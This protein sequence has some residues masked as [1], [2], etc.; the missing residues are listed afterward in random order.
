MFVAAVSWQ[1]AGAAAENPLF[2]SDI[3]PILEKN[4]WICHRG[5]SA[6]AGLDMETYASLLKGGKSGPPIHQGSAGRSLLVEKISSGAMPPGKD[7]LAPEQIALI[8]LWIDHG[9]SEAGSPSGVKPAP[10]LVT[11]DDVLPIFQMRC[12]VCHGKR[13]QEG[14]L[15]LRTRASRL[16]GGRSGPALT[17]GHPEDSLLLRRIVAGQMPPPQLLVEYFVRPPTSDE[18]EML[19]KWIAAG[20][21][22]ARQRTE[23]A[24]ANDRRISE[25]DRA[26]WSF[27]PPKRPSIPTVSHQEL[28]RNPIDA[29]LLEKLEARG[30]TFSPAADKLTLL[31][32]AYLDVTG[33]PPSSEEV[34]AYLKDNEPGAYE[35]LID[36][37][38]ASPHYG[39][40]WAQF[41]LDAAGYSDSEGIIDE[42]LIR[43]NAWRYRDYVIRSLNHDKPYGQFLTEQIAGDELVDYKHAREITPGLID[44]LVATGF[45]RMVP[46]GTYSPANGSVAERVN[47]IADEIEVLGSSVLGLPIG[48]ARCHDHKYD[49]IPQRDY[50][51]FSA[52]LQTAYDPYDWLKPTERKLDIA[53]E[54]ERHEVTAYNAPIEAEITRLESALESRAKPFRDKLLRQR[55]TGL[56]EEVRADVEA[57]NAVSEEK[58]SPVQRY[59]VE[60][61]ATLLK[62][63]DEELA[64]KFPEFKTDFEKSRKAVAEL[65]KTLRDKP[66]I[67][68]LYDMGGD[69]SP[70]YLLRRGDAQLIGERVE[71]GVPSVL[72]AGLAPYRVAAPRPDSSGRRL[73]LARWLVQPDHPLTARVMVNRL[74]MHHFGRGL[75]ASVAN[76]GHTGAPPSHPEL[77]DWLATEFVRTGW[78]MKAM[79]RLVL[80]STAYRQSSR[81]RPEARRADPDNVLLSRM[82]MRRMDAEQLSD[83]ILKVTG[84][85]D[86]AAFGPPAPVETLPGGE[87][88]VRGTKQRWRRSIYTLH[89]RTTPPTMLEAFDLPPMTPNC[90]ER[91]YST[92]ST[93]A[94]E[95]MNSATVLHD[96]RYLAG[97]LIDEYPGRLEKQIEQAYWRIL[98]RPPA[99][100]EIGQALQAVADLDR[101]WEAHL[102]EENREAPPRETAQWSALADFCH[103]MLSSAEFA[104]ID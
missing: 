71:P 81:I 90:V 68:A 40:R 98:S 1:C 83:S 64:E 101:Q 42:D 87:L 12:V 5:K 33:L 2:D 93:Q 37:L 58:R 45:L 91:S 41:W 20:A 60:K 13:K 4:C 14:G 97:R 25:R 94:L 9:A 16:K 67:R 62:I 53:L 29:F 44:K 36:R 47:V 86:P 11:E 32:R 56:P 54:R 88:T 104:Y 3:R 74:W 99:A 66:Q 57:A 18:V 17:P 103:A 55:L 10:E 26:F 34:Q 27:R 96:A 8:R 35:R 51:R 6:P 21:P 31:R 22:A 65:K 46:D 28:V 49:P 23:D 82:T 59:L 79:H 77:L 100:E 7:K 75:V 48:C 61:F 39:E 50:Y 24:A 84:R 80:T 73:A 69:P 38:L 19:R 70:C 30:F 63:T 89:R 102:R 43:P 78:S 95:M 72:K 85:L 76:F 92:V 15:D 52:I